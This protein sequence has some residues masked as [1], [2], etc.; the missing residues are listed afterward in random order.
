MSIEC[1][2][3]LDLNV[4]GINLF[5]ILVILVTNYGLRSKQYIAK[6]LQVTFKLPRLRS[7]S[8]LRR[9]TRATPSLT[10]AVTTGLTVSR[11]AE[12]NLPP[13]PSTSQTSPSNSRYD[14]YI[15]LVDSDS[16]TDGGEEDED[17]QRALLVTIF[18][19]RKIVTTIW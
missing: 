14:N 1:A 11:S 2:G 5:F 6:F 8:S 15:M 7:Q 4:K 13:Q 12:G 16:G 18:R 3:H 10:S 17:L 9:P 19:E